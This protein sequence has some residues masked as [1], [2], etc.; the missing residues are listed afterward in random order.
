[1]DR[2]RMANPVIEVLLRQLNLAFDVRSRHGTNLL[3]A[4]R[5]LGP[6]VVAWRPQPAATASSIRGRDLRRGRM[7]MPKSRDTLERPSATSHTTEHK[8]TPGH[9][10]APGLYGWIT[11]TELTSGD[12]RAIGPPLTS[13]IARQS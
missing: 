9:S 7:L 2:S 4:I 3:G 6:D 1:M 10:P 11:H 13:Q 8:D 12:P 5:G